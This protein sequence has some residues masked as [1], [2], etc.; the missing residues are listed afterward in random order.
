MGELE[1]TLVGP[2][3]LGAGSV[4][5][6]WIICWMLDHLQKKLI[7]TSYHHAAGDIGTWDFTIL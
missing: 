7:H 3:L 1:N 2:E 4:A 5:G 6:C